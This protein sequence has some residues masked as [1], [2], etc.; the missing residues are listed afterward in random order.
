MDT[1]PQLWARLFV[2]N[3]AMVESFGIGEHV[4]HF[5]AFGAQQMARKKGMCIKGS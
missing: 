5:D 3:N 4:R 2:T 1:S